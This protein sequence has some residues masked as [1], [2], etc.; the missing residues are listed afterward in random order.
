MT[1]RSS[2]TASRARARFSRS[3]RLRAENGDRDPGTFERHIHGFLAGT[4]GREIVAGVYAPGSLLP[5]V[6][7]LCERFG[8]SRTALREAYNLLTAKALIVARPKVGTR[9]RPKAEWHMFDPD[10]LAWHLEAGPG[11]KF[12]EDLFVLRQ[13]V[14]PAAAALAAETKSEDMIERIA[15]AFSRMERFRDGVGG[16]LVEA[17]LDFHMA[18]LG[19]P[20]N[21]F[22]AALGSLIHASLQGSF[23]VGWEGATRIQADRLTQ[24]GL[25][26]AA[27]RAGKPDAARRRMSELLRDSIA[28]VQ[29]QAARPK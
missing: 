12:F 1:Q 16:D 25:I 11:L 17:D 4:L 19:A 5:N 10:V 23:R 13:M 9:V 27:I 21:P 18:I 3:A 22:L 26:L 24:H 28:D 15:E 2:Q 20:D 6:P 7:D 14:E 29:L 8:V